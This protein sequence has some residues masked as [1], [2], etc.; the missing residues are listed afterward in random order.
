MLSLIC[1]FGCQTTPNVM[2]TEESKEAEEM[3]NQKEHNIYLIP[4]NFEKIKFYIKKNGYA[5]LGGGYR[6]KVLNIYF[7]FFERTDCLRIEYLRLAVPICYFLKISK[8]S[9]KLKRNSK[10]LVELEDKELTREDKRSIYNEANDYLKLILNNI[11]DT[12][13]N[14]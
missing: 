11:K 2:V 12:E 14:K 1:L 7:N 13:K 9:A 6:L 4:E 10:L 8:Y 5:Y 3:D